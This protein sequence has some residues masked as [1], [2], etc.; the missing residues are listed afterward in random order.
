[1]TAQV[2]IDVSA[3]AADARRVLTG[4]RLRGVERPRE[5]A[6]VHGGQRM[7]R[8]RPGQLARLRASQR[9]ELAVGLSLIPPL[10]VPVGLAVPDQVQPRDGDVAE[11]G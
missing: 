7:G 8:E 5:R 11:D 4:N 6:A 10:G 2:E 3:V 9:R 1:M